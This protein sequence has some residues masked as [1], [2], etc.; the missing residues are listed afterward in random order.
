[1]KKTFLNRIWTKKSSRRIAS[2]AFLA[3]VSLSFGVG[4]SPLYAQGD[5]GMRTIKP[6]VGYNDTFQWGEIPE[7]LQ[8]GVKNADSDD[9]AAAFESDYG[10]AA[11]LFFAKDIWQ[12][13]FRY[14][15]IRT[16]EVDFPNEDGTT[17]RKRVWYLVYSA[18]NTGDR[19]RN[20][21]D[22]E[23]ETDVEEGYMKRQNGKP[24]DQNSK[25]ALET[26]ES[27][28]NN[29]FGVYKPTTVKY[30]D[31]GVDAADF[32]IRFIP[33]LVFASSTIKNRLIYE[34]QK[35]GFYVGQVRGT[36]EG[37]YYD[38][39]LPLAF[40]EIAR[41][42]GRGGQIFY[43]SVRMPTVKIKPGETVWGIATWTD[44][45][46]R[47]DNF[48][49]YV[50]GLTN[51]NRWEVDPEAD[52]D[53]IGAGRE[54]YRKVLKLNFRNP[55]DEIHR[56]GKEIYNSLPGELDYQWIYL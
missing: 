31:P 8:E 49:V 4:A 28:S 50:S 20:V 25:L 48:S 7:I 29:L 53:Q 17:T 12:L 46:P 32:E 51:A 45:D 34:K 21:L 5:V 55:G 56:G 41:K 43:D 40:A 3:C 1:M 24:G 52:F 27:P 10:W 16:I 13:E 9:K 18:T 37:V 26:F 33:R 47:I 6:F 22:A 42:E 38:Q 23:H 35:D 44:V 39:Y 54:V 36:E 11:D 30:D 19:I 15:N 2:A 14:K